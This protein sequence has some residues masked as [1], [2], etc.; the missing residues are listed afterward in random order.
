MEFR[1]CRVPNKKNRYCAKTKTTVHS[2]ECGG[3]TIVLNSD[4]AETRIGI[5]HGTIGT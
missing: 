3:Y 4:C 5:K 1:L 2:S